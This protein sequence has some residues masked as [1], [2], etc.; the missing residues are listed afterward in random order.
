MG[1]GLQEA[2]DISL[3]QSLQQPNAEPLA[4]Q[5]H[6]ALAAIDHNSIAAGDAV[7]GYAAGSQAAMTAVRA[8]ADSAAIAATEKQP[9][10]EEQAA[11]P[12]AASGP[13]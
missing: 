4:E 12:A 10:P 6:G 11:A 5:Q 7:A 8:V 9:E 3:D 2:G 13:I 1:G